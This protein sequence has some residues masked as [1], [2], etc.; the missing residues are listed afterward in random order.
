MNAIH[1]PLVWFGSVRKMAV[2]PLFRPYFLCQ[3]RGQATRFE[4]A[5]VSGVLRKNAASTERNCTTMYSVASLIFSI[6]VN[7]LFVNFD[8]ETRLGSKQKLPYN[9]F[10]NC[11]AA[12]FCTVLRLVHRFF[13]FS[14]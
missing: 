10:I 2:A 1:R 13:K 11:F 12:V 14:Y 4:N 5:V 6:N 3:Q 7:E 8:L 9:G